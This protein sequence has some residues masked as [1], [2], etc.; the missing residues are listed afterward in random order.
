MIAEQAANPEVE[1]KCWINSMAKRGMRKFGLLASVMG[2]AMALGAC[3]SLITASGLL[4]GSGD[5]GMWSFP[6]YL[7][8]GNSSSYGQ[9][10]ARSTSG[11]EVVQS[12]TRS[13]TGP[14]SV[15]SG[16]TTLCSV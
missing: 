16:G 4:G 10:L 7:R 12:L 13:L 6:G 3:N 5:Q 9:P 14:M 2:L 15:A 8:A 1:I 11:I